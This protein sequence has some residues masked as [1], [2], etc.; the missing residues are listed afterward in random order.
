MKEPPFK[1]VGLVFIALLIAV[2]IFTMSFGV[3]AFINLI[4]GA[5]LK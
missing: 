2:M 4:L 3:G 5:T 1:A